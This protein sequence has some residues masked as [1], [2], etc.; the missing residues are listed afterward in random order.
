[1]QNGEMHVFN[2]CQKVVAAWLQH[3]Q[4]FTV[5]VNFQSK[6]SSKSA[7]NELKISRKQQNGWTVFGQRISGRAPT[8]VTYFWSG[9]KIKTQKMNRTRALL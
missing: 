5:T 6:T 8:S 7:E 2:T 9:C 3:G 4:S 1:V